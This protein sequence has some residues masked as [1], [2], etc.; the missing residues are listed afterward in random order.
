MRRPSQAWKTR[1]CGAPRLCVCFDGIVPGG[2]ACET[3]TTRG[4]GVKG[5]RVERRSATILSMR[6]DRLDAHELEKHYTV[7]VAVNLP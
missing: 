3:I 6:A 2:M 7:K 5:E 1:S 4:L